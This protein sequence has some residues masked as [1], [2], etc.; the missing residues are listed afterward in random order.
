VPSLGQAMR[1]SYGDAAEMP[2]RPAAVCSW[3]AER[4]SEMAKQEVPGGGQEGEKEANAT[5]RWFA[6]L[7]VVSSVVVSVIGTLIAR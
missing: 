7:A 5:L 2:A 6:P 4:K 1:Y 3:E